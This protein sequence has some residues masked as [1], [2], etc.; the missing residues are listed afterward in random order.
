MMTHS[1]CAAPQLRLHLSVGAARGCWPMLLPC[2]LSICFC[3]VRCV[4]TPLELFS[5][6]FF[7]FFPLWPYATV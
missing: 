7:V 4:G 1:V 3:S 5:T 2:V 6:F